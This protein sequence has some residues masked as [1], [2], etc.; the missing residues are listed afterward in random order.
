MQ[1][2]GEI[3]WW[4]GGD[5]GRVQ[6]SLR[7]FGDDLDP[8][9]VSALLDSPPTR[10]YCKGEVIPGVR[11]H[12]TASTGVWILQ[13]DEQGDGNLEE[14]IHR[15]L[16]GVS[17]ASAA[18]TALAPYRKDVFC[19]LHLNAWNQGCSLSSVL[20]E[21]LGERGLTLDLDIYGDG[22]TDE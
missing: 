20:L 22:W 3:I 19:G 8:T 11:T 9:S 7:I 13:G 15:L 10:S 21:R 5:I 17:A 2:A 1:P 12:R 16:D 14:R 18:W 6:V 4:L